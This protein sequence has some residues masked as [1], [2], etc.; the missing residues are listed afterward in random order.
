VDTPQ[1]EAHRHGIA[2]ARPLLRALV[3]ALAGAACF[4]APWTPAAVLGAALLALAALIA[5]IGVARWD[6]THLFVTRNALVVEHGFLSRRTASISL[7]G[8][9]FEVERTLPGRLFGYGTV[10]AGELEMDYVPRRLTRLLQQR[11]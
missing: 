8:T 10:I 11:R 6:R 1:I 3:L 5:V 4:L 9:V 2:L 7:N